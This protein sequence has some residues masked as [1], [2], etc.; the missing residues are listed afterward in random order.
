MGQA[1][2]KISNPNGNLRGGGRR[3]PS[4]VPHPLQQRASLELGFREEAPLWPRSLNVIPFI[5]FIQ[6]RRAGLRERW[7]A[8]LRGA[9]PCPL[10]VLFVK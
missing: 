2:W 6:H 8:E 7:E 5:P 10:G 9:G 1:A 3:L 4:T